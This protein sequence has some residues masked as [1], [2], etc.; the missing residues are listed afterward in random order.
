MRLYQAVLKAFGLVPRPE[1][2]TP[3]I[4]AMR[5]ACAACGRIVAHTQAGTPY[6]HRCRPELLKEHTS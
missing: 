4:V 5:R 6:V 2:R 3:R 1:P